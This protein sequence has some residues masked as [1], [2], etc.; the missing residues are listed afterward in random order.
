[1][2]G[3]A[4]G[5]G[6][7]VPRFFIMEVVPV[8]QQL[9]GLAVTRSENLADTTAN[10]D[11]L[12]EVHAIL[13]AHAVNLEKMVSD[14]RILS[15]DLSGT[16]LVKLPMQQA[17]SS[18]MPGKVNPVIPEFVISSAHRIYSND[19]L[20]TGLS[21]MGNL[22]LNAY[23]PAI[24]AAMIE[25]LNLLIAM[26]A[27]LTDNLLKGMTI[28]AGVSYDNLIHSPAI[29]TALIPYI[30]YNK[31][32]ELATLM[33]SRKIN[34]FDANAQIAV[35]KQEKLKD[36]LKPDNL[37]KLGYSLKDLTEE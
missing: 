11:A 5:T 19:N 7:A 16:P 4:I 33:K 14:L 1:L 25:S 6:L 8:L 21:A 35:I 9:T 28:N 15:A 10:L 23:L 3:S 20:I 26:N 29:T 22:E 30:G 13:K 17:G 12:V 24:G 31:A 32:T 27:T 18:I 37:L 2:G 36:V 34:V